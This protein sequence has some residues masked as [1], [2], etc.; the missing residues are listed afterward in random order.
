MWYLISVCN[1][2]ANLQVREIATQSRTGRSR[3]GQCRAIPRCWHTWPHGKRVAS[4]LHDAVAVVHVSVSKD[5]SLLCDS[6]ADI[7]QSWVKDRIPVHKAFCAAKGRISQPLAGV[8]CKLG[9]QTG[10]T[11]VSTENAYSTEK[12]KMIWAKLP[13]YDFVELGGKYLVFLILFIL[14]IA[15]IFIIMILHS[16]NATRCLLTFNFKISAFKSLNCSCR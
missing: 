14:F 10:G 5:L 8:F 12:S 16:L 3:Q 2:L 6:S 9:T 4:I 7:S 13:E 15:V 1:I 11:F